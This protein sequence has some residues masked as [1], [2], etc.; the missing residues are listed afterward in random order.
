LDHRSATGMVLSP[1]LLISDNLRDRDLAYLSETREMSLRVHSY[2]GICLRWATKFPGG[3]FFLEGLTEALAQKDCN[4]PVMFARC[5]CWKRLTFSCKLRFQES[6][7]GRANSEQLCQE[8]RNWRP[9]VITDWGKFAQ[10][11]IEKS[12][13]MRWHRYFEL[14]ERGVR[15]SRKYWE[16]SLDLPHNRL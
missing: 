7:E 13:R 14:I 10:K 2:R 12:V 9:I 1:Q 11:C 8:I 5:G 3:S 15:K 16:A 4:M 6:F